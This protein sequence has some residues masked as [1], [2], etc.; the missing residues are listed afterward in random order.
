MDEAVRDQTNVECLKSVMENYL[1]EISLNGAAE[2][3]R[4][5]IILRFKQIEDRGFDKIIP[6]IIIFGVDDF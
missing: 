3:P 4:R 1:L 2:L 5:R 6:K